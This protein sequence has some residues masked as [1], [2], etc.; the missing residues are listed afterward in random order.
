ML[1][2]FKISP[3][4][5]LARF[6]V[7]RWGGVFQILK[8]SIERANG[9]ITQVVSNF[10]DRFPVFRRVGQNLAGFSYPALIQKVIEIPE[11]EFNIYK[12]SH[13][14]FLL[15]HGISQL[16]DGQALLSVDLLVREQILQLQ[17]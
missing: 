1:A 17:P 14:V 5:G 7:G 3:I 10:K 16:A 8:C 6:P 15:V 2:D 12:A 4:L 11:T 13:P 9:L